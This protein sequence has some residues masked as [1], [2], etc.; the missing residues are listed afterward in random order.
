MQIIDTYEE[1]RSKHLGELQRL[2]PQHFE[3]T[4]WSRERLRIEQTARLGELIRVAQ[5]RSPWHRERLS[6]IDPPAGLEGVPVMTKDDLMANFD[7]IVTDPRLTLEVVESHLE[8]ISRDAYLLDGYH[9]VASGGASGR[10]GVFVWSWESWAPC[11]LGF[12]RHPLRRRLRDPELAGKPLV[13]ASVVAQHATHMSSA[14][15]QSF[16]NPAAIV[17]LLP[18][19]LPYEQIVAG[20]NEA[21]PELVLGFASALHR[22][23]LEAQAGNLRIAPRGLISVAEPLLPEIRGALETTWTAPIY[24]WWGTS[25]AGPMA[26][27]CGE[28]PGMHLSEDLVIV[29]PVDRDGKPVAPGERA[30]KVYLTNLVNHALPLI[31]YELTDEVTLLDEP[32]PCGSAHRLIGDIEG[33]LDDGFVYPGV[34]QVHPHVFRSPLG[35]ERSVVEY[36]VRQTPHGAAITVCCGGELDVAR[37]RR[38]LVAGLERQG[39]D[40]PE[41]SVSQADRLERQP[42]GKLKRFVP[43]AA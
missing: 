25:E 6:G 5:E 20:L 42:S 35:R 31:R 38:E 30:A 33:R 37:L 18:V 8:G 32:C 11:Y 4:A 7:E 16:A 3:R 34:G 1:L 15:S 26:A 39:L 36:V 23:A 41:I 17:H 29:E 10:R 12:L 27:S 21:Q 22:L 9:A 13:L 40:R 43:L 2:A 28:G 14:L 19:T 24:N